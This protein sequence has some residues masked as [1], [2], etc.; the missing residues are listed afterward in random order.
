MPGFSSVLASALLH[1]AVW[2]AADVQPSPIHLLLP[3]CREAF[4]AAVVTVVQEALR[5]PLLSLME[6]STSESDKLLA[7]EGHV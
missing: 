7:A 6:A 5:E 4:P 3:A 2:C 1:L